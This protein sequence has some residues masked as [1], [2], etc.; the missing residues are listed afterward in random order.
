MK[1]SRYNRFTAADDGVIIAFNAMTGALATLSEEQLSTVDKILESPDSYEY[2]GEEDRSLK[3]DLMR[4]G[5]L[6]DDSLDELNLLKIRSQMQRFQTTTSSVTIALT[7]KCNF[8]CPY[9]FEDVAN[10]ETAHGEVLEAIANYVVGKIKGGLQSLNVTWFGGEP[11]LYI[12]SLE[13]LASLFVEQCEEAHCKYSALIITNGYLLTRAMAERLKAANVGSVQITIDGPEELHDKR[14]FLAGGKG[15]F[16]RI[17]DNIKDCYDILPI[18]IRVNVDNGNAPRMQDFLDE[19]EQQELKGCVS[20]YFAPVEE[21]SDI[22]KDSCGSCMNK[23]TF[24][25]LQ[26]ELERK[27]MEMGFSMPRNP[28][29]R[30]T[31]CTADRSNSVVIGPDG[32]LYACYTHIGNEREAIGDVWD[33]SLN[34]NSV[35]WLSWSPF[36]KKLCAEC[37]VL[38]ICMGGCLVEGFKEPDTQKGHCEVYKF[39]LDD[40]LKL[41]Y[42]GQKMFGSSEEAPPQQVAPSNGDSIIV[43][44]LKRP[45][46][47]SPLVQLRV[48]GG[49]PGS[50]VCT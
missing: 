19:L 7:S 46:R 36:D 16:R 15:T 34:H 20:I 48:A 8:R 13:K 45:A 22:T 2:S 25:K 37:D 10:G 28:Q 39:A 33:G 31:F 23:S 30:F 27:M 44:N 6:L 1:S 9:C 12:N 40:H 43:G 32:S 47:R 3:E 5:F 26:I 14:R 50:D 38:P 29:P 24:S 35:K 42:D 41:Y 4:G 21:Y 18:A 17:I 49:T 11:L